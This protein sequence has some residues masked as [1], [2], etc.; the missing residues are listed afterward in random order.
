MS[1]RRC[2]LV[3]TVVGLLCLVAGAALWVPW[4]PV[5]G[6]EPPGVRAESVFTAD[7]V[8][9][10]ED[11]ASWARTW[12][13]LSLAIIEHWFLVLP[14]P[15]DRLWQWGLRSREATHTATHP[16]APVAKAEIAR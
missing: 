15:F 6:G 1:A 13:L 7:E 2:A 14:L 8:E 3:V 4:D 10:G 11:Y 9:R 16:P 5:P 12:S